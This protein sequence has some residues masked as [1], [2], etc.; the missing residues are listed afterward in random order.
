MRY[1]Q[2]MMQSP[3]MQ[4]M[5]ASLAGQT[6]AGPGAPNTLSPLG[7]LLGQVMLT[8]EVLRHI[9]IGLVIE[10]AGWMK[11][12]EREK[13]RCGGGDEITMIGVRQRLPGC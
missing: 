6:G 9:C 1:M 10:V 8:I 3:E 12:G 11:G 2:Q 7:G 4:Q 5:A 13:E